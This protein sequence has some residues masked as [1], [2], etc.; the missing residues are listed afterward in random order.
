MKGLPHQWQIRLNPNSGLGRS[1][2]S[3]LGGYWDHPKWCKTHSSTQES[4]SEENNDDHEEPESWKAFQAMA[5]AR[6]GAHRAAQALPWRS[7]ASRISSCSPGSQA[8]T[9]KPRPA[10]GATGRSCALQALLPPSSP[11]ALSVLKGE[12]MSG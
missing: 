2:S 3:W 8:P 9:P 4:L 7:K 1:I 5:L 10:L 12:H 11:L 6:V